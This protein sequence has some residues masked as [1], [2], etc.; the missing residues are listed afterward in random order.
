MKKICALLVSAVLLLSAAGF[1]GCARKGETFYASDFD[2]TVRNTV[3]TD[4]F[5]RSFSVESPERRDQYVGIFYF[6]WQNSPDAQ[7]YDITKEMEKDLEAFWQYPGNT[8]ADAFH[9]WGEPLYGYYN[10]ED[11]WVLRKHV[12][13]FI[14]ADIDFLFLDATNGFT[15]DSTWRKLLPILSEYKKAGWKVPEVVFYCSSQS[16]TTIT[17]LY[18]ELYSQG[19]CK[20]V[21]FSPNGKPMIIGWDRSED[22][23]AGDYLGRGTEALSEEI[24]EFFDIQDRI[25]PAGNT[26]T[27]GMPWIDLTYPQTNFGGAMS[28]SVSQHAGMPFSDSVRPGATFVDKAK[29]YGRGYDHDEYENKPE[30]ANEG[31]NF[32]YEWRTALENKES[33]QYIM[34]TSWNEWIAQK[35]Q[36]NTRPGEPMFVDSVTREFSRDVEMMKG[37][38][39]DSFYLQLIRNMR[40][41]NDNPVY[42]YENRKPEKFGLYLA[43][44]QWEDFGQT[45]RDPEDEVIVRDYM[46]FSKC[47]HYYDDTARN[48]ITRVRVMNSADGK[49]YIMVETKND[50]TAHEEGDLTWMNILINTNRGVS[51]TWEGYDFVVNRYPSNDGTT[52][53]ERATGNGALFEK[54]ADVRYY[55]ERNRMIVEI[56]LKALGLKGDFTI[57]FKVSD[58]VQEPEDIMSYYVYGDSAP[59]GRMNYRYSA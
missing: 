9:F 44:R 12:E 55:T 26:L 46:G 45:Y 32:E 43:D 2:F 37:G 31:L 59:V 5:G 3:A 53:L 24:K 16:C 48:D 51:E 58:N 13:L 52:S 28:V 18:E 21:W 50:I 41:L 4:V 8:T 35:L 1:A 56:P 29:N 38:Y 25:W 33:L 22:P 14:Y 15:Y 54:A 42:G 19:F 11:E 40:A 7:V 23:S 20:D 10:I 57:D 6:L 47:V 30:K 36:H 27:E 39:E 17:H 34:V 49:L